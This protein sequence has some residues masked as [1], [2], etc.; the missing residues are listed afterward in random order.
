MSENPSYIV[1]GA[2]GFIGSN[3]VGELL[4]Q[5]PGARIIAVDDFRSGSFANVVQACSRIAGTTY[6]GDFLPYCTDDL[7]WEALLDSSAPTAV[8]H[9]A[10]ITD[11]TVADEH[12][13]MTDNAEGFRPILHACIASA[14]PLVY[15]SS[16][17]TYGSPEQGDDREP[18]AETAAGQPNNVYGFSKWVMENQHRSIADQLAQAGED[19]PSVVGLRFF[20]VFGA[21]ESH[22]GKMASIAHQLSLQILA[23]NKPRLFTAGEQA[24]DQVAVMDVVDCMLAGAKPTANPGVYNCGSGQA[25]TFNDLADAVRQGLNVTTADAPTEYFHMPDSIAAFYQNYTCADMTQTRKALDWSPARDPLQAISEYAAHLAG[26][27]S[28]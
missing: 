22:K 4:R 8:F 12:T 24:R 2:A 19:E 23:G 16:A 10:A 1:T 21:G 7:D 25:T 5:D 26:V 27:A 14:V 15:A 20:N 18:F 11:T 6:S 13:M 9:L 28:R 3:L 17:A